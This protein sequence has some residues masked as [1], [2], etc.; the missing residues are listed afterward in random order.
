MS[1]TFGAIELMFEEVELFTEDGPFIFLGV[2]GTAETVKVI[3]S[4][5][6]LTDTFTAAIGLTG[7]LFCTGLIMA[8]GVD[9]AQEARRD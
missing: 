6:P 4:I 7:V 3:F 8:F 2:A 1:A 5:V 9:V